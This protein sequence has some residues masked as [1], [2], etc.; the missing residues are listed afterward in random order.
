RLIDKNNV[1]YIYD[2]AQVNAILGRKGDALNGL[3]EAL[4]KHFPAPYAANDPE[5][6]ELRKLPGFSTLMAQYQIPKH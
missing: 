6:G 2:E 3:R 1:I 4:Q 5:L